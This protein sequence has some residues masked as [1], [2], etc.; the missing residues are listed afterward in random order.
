[1]ALAPVTEAELDAARRYVL[2]SMALSTATHAGLASTLS[3]LTGSGLPPQWLAEHQQ[4]LARVTV[5]EVQEAAR[6]VL[7]PAALTGVVVGDAERVTDALRALGPV[8]VTA[9]AA[10]DPT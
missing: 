1:M 10:A 3:A 6:R 2:G 9:S 4:A 5:E 8:D 7:Q